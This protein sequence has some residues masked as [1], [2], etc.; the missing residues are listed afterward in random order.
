MSLKCDHPGCDRSGFKS[1]HALSMHKVRTHGPKAK[2]WGKKPIK[3]TAS[4]K[5]KRRKTVRVK[6][7][8][9]PPTPQEVP[10]SV[11]Q[12]PLNF[13]PHCGGVL[14]GIESAL[15]Q[16][17]REMQ[18]LKSTLQ[19]LGSSQRTLL[20]SRPGRPQPASV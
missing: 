18:A 13:C 10:V 16:S 11:A 1:K 7:P 17:T 19:P 2:T 6:A 12:T 4:T 8:A 15:N 9:P 5:A 20:S 3:K 14:A